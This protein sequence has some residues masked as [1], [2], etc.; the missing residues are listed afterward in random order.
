MG[1]IVLT[2][3]TAERVLALLE[4][5]AVFLVDNFLERNR[6]TFG[7]IHYLLNACSSHPGIMIKTQSSTQGTHSL[8]G[9]IGM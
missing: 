3:M 6:N 7:S 8:V 5:I 2:A 9:M 1:L 4:N